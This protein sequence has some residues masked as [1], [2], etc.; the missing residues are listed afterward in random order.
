M[1]VVFM[2]SLSTAPGVRGRGVSG[3]HRLRAVT[4]FLCLAILRPVLRSLTLKFPTEQFQHEEVSDLFKIKWLK[5]DLWEQFST[6]RTK[7]C[8]NVLMQFGDLIIFSSPQLRYSWLQWEQ[9]VSVLLT[10]ASEAL[11]LPGRFCV[12]LAMACLPSPPWGFP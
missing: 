5:I 10:L 11:H 6:S 1:S 12:E 3:L 9:Q 8:K 4:H 2:A 7:S